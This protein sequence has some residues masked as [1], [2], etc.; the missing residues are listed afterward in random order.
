M[1]APDKQRTKRHVC[2]RPSVYPSVRPSVRLLD[3]VWHS[4]SVKRIDPRT[5]AQGAKNRTG[6][7]SWTGFISGVPRLTLARVEIKRKCDIFPRPPSLC[8]LATPQESSHCTCVLRM[9]ENISG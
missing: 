1:D 8:R 9:R 5:L 6:R 7:R 4:L 2:V 3:G